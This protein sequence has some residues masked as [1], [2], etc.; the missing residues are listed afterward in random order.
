[1]RRACGSL[2]NEHILAVY[3]WWWVVVIGGFFA[4]IAD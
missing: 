1:M 3:K 4:G 2:F